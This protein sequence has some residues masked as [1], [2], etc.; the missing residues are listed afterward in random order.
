METTW[1]LE[2]LLFESNEKDSDNFTLVVLQLDIKEIPPQFERLW[3]KGKEMTTHFLLLVSGFSPTQPSDC[4][5]GV[6]KRVTRST[7][8]LGHINFREPSNA[9]SGKRCRRPDSE[10]SR[11]CH[12]DCHSDFDTRYVQRLQTRF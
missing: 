8:V 2:K 12:S 6:L 3:T 1:E 9:P 7:S 4:S 10:L 5:C 11:D